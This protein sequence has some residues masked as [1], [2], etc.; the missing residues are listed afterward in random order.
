MVNNLSEKFETSNLYPKFGT[1]LEKMAAEKS[2]L[3]FLW[4]VA[5]ET[6][7]FRDTA[8]RFNI[9][10]STLHGIIEKVSKFISEL[11][12][13]VIKWPSDDEKK[14][15]IQGFGNMGFPNVLGCIDGSHIHIDTPSEDPESYFNR[16][17]F[18]S[19]QVHILY[20]Y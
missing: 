3:V 17:K 10:I 6:A 13:S 15:I 19:I 9:S 20:F 2:I 11:S 18:Y 12:K 7:S 1:G 14:D 16:K 4:Y 8:D 5:H